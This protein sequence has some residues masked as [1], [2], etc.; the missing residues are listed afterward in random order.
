MIIILSSLIYLISY[1]SL[2]LLKVHYP[3]GLIFIRLF[4]GIADGI[5]LIGSYLYIYE[6]NCNI[7]DTLKE[8]WKGLN[9][10]TEF[11]EGWLNYK[12]N[13]VKDEEFKKIHSNANTY[14]FL[15]NTVGLFLATALRLLM[16]PLY[17]NTYGWRIPFYIASGFSFIALLLRLF[18]PANTYISSHYQENTNYNTVRYNFK[19]YLKG[20]S[21]R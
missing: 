11:E 10:I 2:C 5:D 12:S 15:G 4:I 14:G 3:L 13:L 17:L 7:D 16:K 21:I 20:F 18:I 19:D 1:I 9:D 8:R 6:K